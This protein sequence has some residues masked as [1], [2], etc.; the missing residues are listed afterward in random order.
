MAKLVFVDDEKEMLDYVKEFFELQ[1][2]EVFTACDGETGS[3]LIIDEC[4]DF[5]VVDLRMGG[6]SGLEVIKRIKMSIPKQKIAIWTGYR[7]HQIEEE[8]LRE[9]AIK[10]FHKP[11]NL[12]NLSNE[13]KELIKL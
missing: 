11:V 1:G 9:G 4:P 13:I 8:A 10:C 3:D 2:H 12:E 6:L 7:N 5:A